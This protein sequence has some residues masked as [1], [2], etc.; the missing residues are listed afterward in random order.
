MKFEKNLMVHFFVGFI[1]GGQ[2]L[3]ISIFAIF[4]LG[5]QGRQNFEF[6]YGQFTNKRTLGART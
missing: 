3:R 6:Q 1:I 2:I 4:Y 5:S